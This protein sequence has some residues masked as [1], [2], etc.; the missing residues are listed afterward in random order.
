[1]QC[2]GSPLLAFKLVLLFAQSGSPTALR[3]TTFMEPIRNVDGDLALLHIGATCRPNARIWN[4]AACNRTLER[5]S[6]TTSL[7]ITGDD[8]GSCA[9]AV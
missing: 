3:A 9:Q 2:V 7:A 6:D 4:G 1:M 8:F 5:V